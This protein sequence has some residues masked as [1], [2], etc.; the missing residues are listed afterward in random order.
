MR[1]NVHK[2]RLPLLAAALLGALLLSNCGYRPGDGDLPA[3]AAPLAAAQP[4][5]TPEPEGKLYTVT[6]R[7]NGM[8]T[9]ELVPEGSFAQSAH[10]TQPFITSRKTR[11]STTGFPQS[12]Q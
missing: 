8:E 10:L 3:S 2:K 1:E 11:S 5:I 9:S 7:V 12:A 4:E 6:Y